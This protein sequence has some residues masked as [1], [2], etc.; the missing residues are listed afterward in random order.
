MPLPRGLHNSLQFRETRTPAQ[1][2]EGLI[3]RS[4]QA[5]RIP[6]PTGPLQSG[7]SF[8]GDFFAGKDHLAYGYPDPLPRLKNPDAPG[9][10]AN[11]CAAAKSLTWM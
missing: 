1:L 6:Q 9:F 7:N 3:C 5:G 11:K 4:H 8:A 2:L 10:R